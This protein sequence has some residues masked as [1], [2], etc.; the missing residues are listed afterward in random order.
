MV[1][2]HLTTLTKWGGSVVLVIALGLP[3]FAAQAGEVTQKGRAVYV[4]TDEKFVEIG[5]VPDH[6]VGVFYCEGIDSIEGVEDSIIEFWGTG[7]YTAGMG[8]EQGYYTAT[9]DDGA[10]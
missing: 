1:E 3:V 10:M 2:A 5:D 9:Y 7:D 4:C 8:P 6:Y